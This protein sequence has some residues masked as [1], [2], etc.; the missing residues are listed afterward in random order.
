MARLAIVSDIHGN[1]IAFE[2]VL[3]DIDR[4]QVDAVLCL[5]DI[6]GY[7]PEPAECI[8]MVRRACR[9]AI[10]GN[11]EDALFDPTETRSWHAVARLAITYTQR[12]LSGEELAFLSELPGSFSIPGAILGVHDSPVPTEASS[13]YLRA[14]GD[15]ARAFRG[16]EDPICLVGHTHVPALYTTA[17]VNA[18]APLALDD[19]DAHRVVP[20]DE[21]AGAASATLAIPRGARTIL[22][23]GSVGQPR[24]G[25]PRAS[26]AILDLAYS[27]AEFHRVRYDVELA[28]RRSVAAGLPLLLSERLALGA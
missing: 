26:Y 12:V 24:D 3:R 14:A 25:D 9:L 6:V 20:G 11:H 27:T 15:F 28:A 8:A 5:G 22:N 21:H 10:R 1:S 19:V 4:R 16:V 13:N 23:P 2:A 18:L 7:G 17:V